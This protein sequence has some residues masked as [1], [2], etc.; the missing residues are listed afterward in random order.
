[1]HSED[2]GAGVAL[3]HALLGYKAGLAEPCGLPCQAIKLAQRLVIYSLFIFYLLFFLGVW[4]LQVGRVQASKL[5]S[6]EW[7]ARPFHALAWLIARKDC[8]NRNWWVSFGGLRCLAQLAGVCSKGL[9]VWP[10]LCPNLT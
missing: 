5:G 10:G 8:P 6:K 2:H 9:R 7:A 3:V 4:S 1:M